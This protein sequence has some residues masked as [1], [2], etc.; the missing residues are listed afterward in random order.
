MFIA[1]RSSSGTY[2]PTRTIASSLHLPPQHLAKVM[3][4]MTAAG[5]LRSHRGPGGGVALARPAEDISLLDVVC[6]LQ[7]AE[8]LQVCPIGRQGCAE[9]P[10]C[11]LRDRWIAQRA[12]VYILFADTTLKDWVDG[13]AESRC[14]NWFDDMNA[15]LRRPRRKQ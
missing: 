2:V 5:V 13:A 3:H 1:R 6:V 12:R 4:T 15:R 7:D 9:D 10:P 11:P 14:T 8:L